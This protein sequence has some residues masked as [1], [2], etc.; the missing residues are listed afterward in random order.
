MLPS[1]TPRPHHSTLSAWPPSLSHFKCLARVGITVW[2]RSLTKATSQFPGD[3]GLVNCPQARRCQSSQGKRPAA[4]GGGE[5]ARRLRRDVSVGPRVPT[6]ESP[7][8]SLKIQISGPYPG[9]ANEIPKNLN[10]KQEPPALRF[11]A[12]RPQKQGINRV[13]KHEGSVHRQPQGGFNT[14]RPCLQSWREER[15]WSSP[16]HSNNHCVF[17][18]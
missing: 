10:F 11:E 13:H 4:W 7:G 5:H 1:S 9:T 8:N 16:L 12:Q 14:G 2:D 3:Q 6:S 17:Q 15:Q 18:F